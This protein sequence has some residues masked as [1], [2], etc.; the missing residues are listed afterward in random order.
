[1]ELYGA[2]GSLV[3]P[4]PNRFGGTVAL[5]KKREAWTD[6]PLSHGYADG[7][8]RII[9]LADLAHAIRNDRPH[10]CSG[11]LGYHV[12][13]VMEAFGLSS[14]TGKVVTITSR[15]ERPAPLPARSALGALD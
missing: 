9:G 11:A 5:A 12:L 14:D 13:E 2:E 8:F 4:D 6:I 15:C 10:R 3:V 7:N 1:M